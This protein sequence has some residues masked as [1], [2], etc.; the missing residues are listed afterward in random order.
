MFVQVVLV[1]TRAVENI[2]IDFIV[3]RSG[4]QFV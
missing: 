4:V 3:T 1:P 2:A